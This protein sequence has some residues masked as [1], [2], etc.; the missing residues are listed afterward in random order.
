MIT[1]E[2]HVGRLIET[3]FASPIGDSEMANFMQQ[4]E[5][6][7][8]SVGTDRLVCIDLSR[9]RVL[10]P[11][12]ADA[13]LS[14]L[15]GSRPGLTRNAFLLPPGQAILA[16]QFSRIIRQAENPAR[17]TFESRSELIDW[18]GELLRPQELARLKVFLS[19]EDPGSR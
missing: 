1:I 10:P 15:R 9:V 8:R 11:N 16:L 12:Q 5:R 18:L 14:F 3:R 13:F 2:N 19:D 6:I 17:R 4:R 7:M